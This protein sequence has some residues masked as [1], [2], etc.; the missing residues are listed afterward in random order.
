MIR[1]NMRRIFKQTPRVLQS[2]FRA[3]RN[4]PE[5][6]TISLWTQSLFPDQSAMFPRKPTKKPS[7]KQHPKQRLKQRPGRKTLRLRQGLQRM[8]R[9]KCLFLKTK[10]RWQKKAREQMQ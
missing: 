9:E 4:F 6:C 3:A 10:R 5:Q 1:A 2:G 8:A 7:S